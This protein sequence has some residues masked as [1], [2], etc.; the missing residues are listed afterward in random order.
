MAVPIPAN[1]DDHGGV[2]EAH[3]TTQGLG[4]VVPELPQ[5]DLGDLTINDVLQA[6]HSSPSWTELLGCAER[7][8]HSGERA[9]GLSRD[10]QATGL[11]LDVSDTKLPRHSLFALGLADDVHGA[12][13]GERRDHTKAK[14]AE[15]AGLAVCTTLE[16]CAQ[17]ADGLAELFR[18]DATSVIHD[19]DFVAL[20]VD[21]D[22]H[23]GS[24]GVD[25]VLNCFEDRLVQR[26]I[27]VR[28]LD[29][30]PAVV[31]ADFG[32]HVF[33]TRQ[34]VTHGSF[35]LV[36]LVAVAKAGELSQLVDELE[37]VVRANHL[38]KQLELVVVQ[39]GRGQHDATVSCTD[40]ARKISEQVVDFVL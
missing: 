18:R 15:G 9:Q 33:R 12:A 8:R 31:E 30:D 19:D 26:R 3:A 25:G 6:N 1:H 35:S 38:A 21:A 20:A 11:L 40:G 27:G 14:A 36:D 32:I 22:E 2:P 5:G 23:D 28:Q 29:D 39:D 16:G 37:H 24:P 7:T 13:L 4:D 17:G 34:L 10:V